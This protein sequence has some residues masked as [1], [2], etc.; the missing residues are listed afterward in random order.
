MNMTCPAKGE[1]KWWVFLVTS[2]VIY[3]VGLSL[4]CIIAAIRWLLVKSELIPVD[5]ADT[6]SSS[7]DKTCFTKFQF[8][9][10]KIQD[11]M[12]H[13]I[14]G[15]SIASK[16]LITGVLLNNVVYIILSI[17]R[18]YDPNQAEH[19]FTLLGDPKKIMELVVVIQL[20][21]FALVRF[22]ASNNI[23]MY[24]FSIYTLV[25]VFTLPHIFVSIAFGVDWIGLRS[26]RFIWLTQ[27]TTVLRFAPFIHSQ[28]TIDLINLLIY[29][30]IVWMMGSGLIHL[31]EIQ[32][33]PWKDFSNGTNEPLLVY[34]YYIMVTFSTVG[35][36]D[37]HPITDTGRAFM[38][39]FIIG[40]L[41]FFAAILPKLVEVISNYYAK[42][43]YAVFDTSRVPQHVIVCGHITS[44]TAEDFLKDF[45]HPDRG[46]TQ[47]HVLFLHHERP[48]PGLKNVLRS[49]YTRI[50]YLLGSVLNGKDLQ[51]A[52]ISCS[53]A[54]FILAN[55]HTD[56]PTEEDNAN[57]L[58]VVSVKNTTSEI[59]IIIQLL[60]SFSKKQ[61]YNIEGWKIGVDIAVCLN[62]LKLGLL[63]QSCLCPGFSTLIANLFYT[64]DFPSYSSFTGDDA[65]KEHY[66]KG[67]SN[68]V[69]SSTFSGAFDGMTFHEAASIC[70]NKLDLVLL[71]LESLT[72]NLHRYF[73]NPSISSY[74][75]L[76][77][78]SNMM[79]GYFIAQDK[80][81]VLK[82]STFC[83]CCPGNKHSDSAENR[84]EVMKQIQE[85]MRKFTLVKRRGSGYP[86][87]N[88][89][90]V[91]ENPSVVVSLDP[92]ASIGPSN[93]TELALVESLD[94]DNISESIY[95]YDS[96][97]EESEGRKFHMYVC[98][99]TKLEVSIL[100]PDKLS[101]EDVISRA[102][103][104]DHIILCIFADGNSPLLGLHNFLKPLRSKHLPAEKIKPVVII[105]SKAFIEK[106]WPIIRSIPQVYLVVGSPLRWSNLQAAKV[107]DCSVCVILTGLSNT[108]SNEQAISDKEAILCSLSIQ[109]RL[110]KLDKKVQV[111]TD[112]R[113]E[114][115]VQFLDFGD[116]DEPDER[117]YK[118]Q[119]FA[120]GEAFSVSM[121]DSI[122]S[123]A[124]HGPGTLYLVEDLIHASGT[125]VQCLPNLIAISQT[126]YPGKTFGE[127]YNDQLGKCSICL[128]LARR[129]SKSQRYVITCPDPSL[130]LEESDIAFMLE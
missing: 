33:D 106:E 121:F 89:S 25:D 96:D 19:C 122:T 21:L 94:D 77:I 117:I 16:I 103:I 17:V 2:A 37:I 111:I 93:N 70:Y 22:L 120:C 119:P 85:H 65:W 98:E 110:K 42:T 127:F 66:I 74:P 32:G 71:A 55:K 129:L 54:I 13:L 8:Y 50:Q 20:I 14:S 5:S 95:D 59:P 48:D 56:N 51:R 109:K 24:W 58:R 79:L 92:V 57:L 43:Q 64:S 84:E 116:E 26:L 52:K 35:Y 46:D 86:D 72:P 82:V 125:D 7:K 100:N 80:E 18:T 1:E 114:S 104:R 97:D 41:A 91:K 44:V 49:Y 87:K 107:E 45:L 62:E 68:E 126:D 108:S 3:I 6:S 67:A 83:E 101:M 124:F 60:H 90:L 130:L 69:Y 63:A 11:F 88:G 99:P 115:N 27:I 39:F 76:K 36:G 81:H 15:D 61:V 34:Y 105:S 78:K 29:F 112:L 31:I 28:D 128:G 23:I 118:A 113:H 47:T 75:E 10:K 4:S 73:V 12:R 40:G 53:K 38:T 123:S 30:L 9:H 102:D